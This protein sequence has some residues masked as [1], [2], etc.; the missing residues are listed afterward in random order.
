MGTQTRYVCFTA[1][2]MVTLLALFVGPLVQWFQTTPE[3]I[4]ESASAAYAESTSRRATVRSLAYSIVL[5][6]CQIAV[7][8]LIG[9][10]LARQQRTWA[11]GILMAPL[12]CGG[13]VAS[14]TW[15]SLLHGG[16]PVQATLKTITGGS[17]NFLGTERVLAP[18]SSLTFY[19]GD[20]AVLLID[21]WVW[22]PITAAYFA[23]CFQRIPTHLIESAKLEGASALWTARRVQ[24]PYILP[25]I[26]IAFLVRWADTFRLFD[27]PWT[28]FR[29]SPSI[30]FM[31]A[32]IFTLSVMTRDPNAAVGLSLVA[33]L[34]S[35]PVFLGAYF[36]IKLVIFRR[37]DEQ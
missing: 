9:L 37:F 31:S 35:L 34:M 26:G 20:L 36:L 7:A 18:S 30:S 6:I 27:A 5:P 2:A 14:L 11:I 24:V 28:L 3:S 10:R 12:S 22:I 8:L 25:H 19:S 13:L 15:K 23:I 32:R 29:D 4:V 21:S 16:G 1:T 33:V 17:P